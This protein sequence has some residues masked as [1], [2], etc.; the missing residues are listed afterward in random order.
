MVLVQ[1]QRFVGQYQ[2]QHG[3]LE[4]CSRVLAA[5]VCDRGEGGM[6]IWRSSSEDKNIDPESMFPLDLPCSFRT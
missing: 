5:L 6:G 1:A 4:G 3:D 2:A